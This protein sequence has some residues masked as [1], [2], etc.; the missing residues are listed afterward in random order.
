VTIFKFH[1]GQQIHV[2]IFN[3]MRGN[4]SLYLKIAIFFGVLFIIG[5]IGQLF[6]PYSLNWSNL[7]YAII[8]IL[9]WVG[10]F[11]TE[12]YRYYY[13]NIALNIIAITYFCFLAIDTALKKQWSFILYGFGVVPFVVFARYSFR[14]IKIGKKIKS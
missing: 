9:F 14:V 2:I 3:K 6:F 7:T 11:L 5:L 13:L 4:Q 8:F 12:R 10:L 1:L